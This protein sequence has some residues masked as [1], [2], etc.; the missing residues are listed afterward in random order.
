MARLYNSPVWK[1][2]TGHRYSNF[3]Y[4][5][6]IFIPHLLTAL[7]EGGSFAF[8]YLAFSAI[9]G[10]APS[11][12]SPI[13]TLNLSSLTSKMTSIE[14]FYFY[15]FV[16]IAFQAVRGVVS[17]LAL[18]G[19][20]VFSLK[21]QTV[22]Q[23]MVYQQ[24]FRFSFPFVS[25][26]KIGDL[27]ECAK[28]PSA[29]IPTM[30]EAI[31]RFSVSVFMCIG[32]IIVLYWISPP[33]TFLTFVLFACFALI[34]KTLLKKVLRYSSQLTLHLF[35][36][37]HHT[38]QSLQGIRPIHIFQR[39]NF[40]LGKIER[41]LNQVV[42]ASKKAHFWNNIIPTVNETVNVLLVG[43]ILI[44]G[45]LI[46]SRSGESSLP[47]LLTYIAL[48]YRLAT[49]LQIAMGALG[50]IGINYG[51]ILKL[52]QILEDQGKEYLPEGGREFLGWE[53]KIEFQDVSL[54]YPQ[55]KYPAIKKVSFSIPFGSSLGIVGLSGA[56]KSS[57]LDLLLGL[58]NPTE[59]K[60]LVD[61]VQL[62]SYSHE[63]WRRLIG[64]VSQDTFI[65]NGSVE[66][67][68]RFGDTEAS[69]QAVANALKLAGAE[70]FINNLPE[71][72]ETIVGERGYKLSGGEKQRLALA[73]A[74]FRSPQILILD[75]ATSNLDS[76]TEHRIQ[77]S[78]ESLTKANT[79]IV[80][81]HRLST[82]MKADQ[83]LV[84]EKGK[85][86]ERGKHAELLSLGGQYAKLWRLQSEKDFLTERIDECSLL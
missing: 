33:L 80:V 39:Q 45:T 25:Q 81:A 47:G 57:L 13:V 34:Q 78:L 46:L 44:L 15:I 53:H 61:G 67:N 56:G 55:S 14:L 74:L 38:L 66:E 30:F 17:F 82:I 21:V 70:G 43:T 64:V 18:Y 12:A 6:P 75:E 27:S 86:I 73:R 9:Q 48:T 1:I 5:I 84:L 79:L 69:H 29:F 10:N 11:Q 50:G 23:K 58:Q 41:V 72:L 24:I 22:L 51:S 77:S 83:I 54:Q 4:L 31:N 35:E 60:I 85:I 3:R 63:S 68:V 52:N 32:L 59:G 49:R 28:T 65:F 37:S 76:L 36:F 16:A 71:G 2:I 19:T 26:Y 40:I 62:N 7:L 42:K 8:I 20:S